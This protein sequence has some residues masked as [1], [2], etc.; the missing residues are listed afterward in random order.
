[1]TQGFDYSKLTGK[2]YEIAEMADNQG[3]G[4]ARHNGKLEGNE[5]SIFESNAKLHLGNEGYDYTKDDINAVLGFE[6]KSVETAPV[7]T[8]PIV[9]SK[10]DGKKERAE[11]KDTVKELVKQTFS[12]FNSLYL[13]TRTV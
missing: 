4:D 1:M 3:K 2:L 5:L 11:V 9:E 12:P 7:A 13:V 8:N 6:K 10:K